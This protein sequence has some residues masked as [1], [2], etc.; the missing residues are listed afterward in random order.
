[1]RQISNFKFQMRHLKPHDPEPNK[2][3]MKD[4]FN[5]FF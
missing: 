1:M 4:D 3:N 2:T 5:Y